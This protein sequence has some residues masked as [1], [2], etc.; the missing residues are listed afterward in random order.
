MDRPPPML[1][2]TISFNPS[3][4]RGGEKQKEREKKYN[5][6]AKFNTVLVDPK[7][8]PKSNHDIV[9]FSTN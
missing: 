9:T 5:N 3:S 6:K 1:S 8:K 4:Q 7:P 2:I